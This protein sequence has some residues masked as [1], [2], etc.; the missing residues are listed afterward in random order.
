MNGENLIQ[1]A[2]EKKSLITLRL[3]HEN[4]VGN[5]QVLLNKQQINN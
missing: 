4:F 3:S 2:D 1:S 5:H